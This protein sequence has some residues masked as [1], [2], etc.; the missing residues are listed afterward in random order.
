VVLDPF[1]G[2]GT[3]AVAATQQ[4]RHWLGVELTEE[5]C[6]IAR[7]RTAEVQ[8]LFTA[9]AKAA[10]AAPAPG[11]EPVAVQPASTA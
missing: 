5:D 7:R 11:V 9:G 1:L 10:A 3:T 2:S 6:A 4:G 8:G